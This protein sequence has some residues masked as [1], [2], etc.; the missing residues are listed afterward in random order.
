MGLV[1]DTSAVIQLER[2]QSALPAALGNEPVILPVIVWAEL[3]IGVRLAGTPQA[4]SQ[5][6][7]Q[8]E[9][10]R[11]T[12]SFS[13]MTPAIAEH[14]A[15]I[16]VGLRRSGK[17]IPQNDLIVAATARHFGYGVLVGPNDESH[18]RQVSGLRVE[19]LPL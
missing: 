18:F 19:V 8:L 16:Y 4:V 10:L 15:D 13:E 1:I 12:M 2:K 9:K 7:N 11:T 3:L 5:R 17:T 6:R 14:H